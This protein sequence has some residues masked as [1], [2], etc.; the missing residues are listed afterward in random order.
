MKRKRDQVM[1]DHR[2]RFDYAANMVNGVM[3]PELRKI[4][5]PGVDL[6]NAADRAWY[7]LNYDFEDLFNIN[8]HPVMRDYLSDYFKAAGNEIDL[9]TFPTPDSFL[10]RFIDFRTSEA[11]QEKA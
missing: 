11:I 7:Y 8:W 3:V 9:D 4:F 6:Q 10:K 5:Q 2:N 1:Q